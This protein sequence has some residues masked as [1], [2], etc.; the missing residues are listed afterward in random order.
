M[1]I[2]KE[3]LNYVMPRQKASEIRVEEDYNIRVVLRRFGE[4]EPLHPVIDVA[5][6]AGE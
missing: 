4:P 5:G 6:R 3:L 2:H 1:N